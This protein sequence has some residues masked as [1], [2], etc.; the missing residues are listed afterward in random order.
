M[1]D[2]MNTRLEEGEEKISDLEDRGMESN[3]AVHMRG[4]RLCR[5]RIDL[6]NSTTPPNIITFAL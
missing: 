6:W 5:V 4:K 3:Q 1:L 2:G